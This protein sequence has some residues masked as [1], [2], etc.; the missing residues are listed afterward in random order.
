MMRSHDVP[1]LFSKFAARDN[2]T[3]TLSAAPID[4]ATLQLP[5]QRIP[6]GATPTIVDGHAPHTDDSSDDVQDRAR[7]G[8]ANTP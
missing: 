8:A 7:G 2:L 6:A 4:P 1:G 3:P 5:H